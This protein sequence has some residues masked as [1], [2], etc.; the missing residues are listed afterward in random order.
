MSNGSQLDPGTAAATVAKAGVRYTTLL[1][2]ALAAKQDAEE[3]GL[4]LE[5]ASDEKISRL[6]QKIT[7]YEKL[8]DKIENS[9]SDYLE[10]TA[11]NKPDSLVYDPAKLS[12]AVSDNA[13]CI[14]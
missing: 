2:M 6:V 13:T 7:K 3:D 11:V 4:Y 5:T 14:N 1:N 8:R 9:Y 10:F 12:T